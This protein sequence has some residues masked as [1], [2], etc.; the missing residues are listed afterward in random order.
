MEVVG[1]KLRNDM[2]IIKHVWEYLDNRVR[3]QSSLPTNWDQM[4]T[5]LQEE[6]AKIDED[7]IY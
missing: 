4:W 1:E 2:N 3:T 7:Y 5:A 6:W